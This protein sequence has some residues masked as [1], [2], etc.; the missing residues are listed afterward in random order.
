MVPADAW[1]KGVGCRRSSFSS[2]LLQL[3]PQ[4]SLPL[5][6]TSG[7]SSLLLLSPQVSNRNIVLEKSAIHPYTQPRE[8]VRGDRQIYRRPRWAGEAWFFQAFKC[9][10]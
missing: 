2:S 9:C 6:S 5:L 7:L 8:A 1:V 4:V 3:S 10:R